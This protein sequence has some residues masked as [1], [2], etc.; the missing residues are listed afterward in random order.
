MVK[1]KKSSKPT[2]AT[3]TVNIS[4]SNPN[5]W[6][7]YCDR[8]FL[9]EKILITHQ[10]CRHFKCPACPRK[11][12]SP[13]GLLVHSAQVHKLTLDKV[14]NAIE[15]RDCP[16]MEVFGMRG[17][18]AEDIKR[19][20]EG[21]PIIPKR[22]T[23]QMSDIG[24]VSIMAAEKKS[25]TSNS[26]FYTSKNNTDNDSNNSLL[27]SDLK[28]SFA[29]KEETISNK[30]VLLPIQQASQTSACLNPII[31]SPPPQKVITGNINKSVK[32]DLFDD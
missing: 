31:I 30:I 29:E 27:V 32:K 16:E 22:K 11:L 19:K 23:I 3:T 12:N 7:W 5:V 25:N 24:L 4:A 6:C 14:P 18:S 28:P 26:F 9:D 8:H 15:E 20:R 2:V 10:R 17:I 13:S 1:A 21:L